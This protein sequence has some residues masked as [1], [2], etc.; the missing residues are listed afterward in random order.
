MYNCGMHTEILQEFGLSP[1]E[2]EL[3]LTLL[4]MGE[5][6]VAEV[7][8]TMKRH[9][10]VVYRLIDQLAA[11]GLLLSDVRR[12]RRV[13][14]AEDPAVFLKMQEEKVRK[15]QELSPALEAIRHTP[16]DA[17]VRVLRG[18]EAVRSLRKR[19]FELMQ[20]GDI[21]YILSASGT[22]F[23]EVMGDGLD[24]LERR[25][26]E[27]GIHK[28]ILAFESQREFLQRGERWNLTELRY[29]PEQFDVP[30]STNIFLNTVAIIVWSFEP[31]VITIESSEVA[32]SYKDYFGSLWKGAMP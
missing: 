5:V 16:K 22:R 13:I 27:R 15:L 25:R 14:R 21:Y 1:L 19:A 31:I 9:P 26:V 23:Y 7:T 10:Q 6:P 12:H 30:S 32:Q 8:K 3:Y 11:R 20:P 18:N 17:T 2:I 28:Q 24:R 29:L 4:P